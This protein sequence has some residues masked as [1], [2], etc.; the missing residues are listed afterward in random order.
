[1]SMYDCKKKYHLDKDGHCDGPLPET[2]AEGACSSYC[3]VRI[4]IK[5]GQEVPYESS[6]CSAVECTVAE[7]TG[8]STT[9]TWEINM[10]A[11]IEGGKGAV[12]GAFNIGASYSFSKTV[13]Y[14]VE[15]GEKQDL[16]EGESGYWTWVPFLVEYEVGCLL[17][18]LY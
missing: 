3:E 12:T 7:G 10:S 6:G 8:T 11:G 14:T 4:T 13:S 9:T 1:M 17:S 16:K 18:F 5:Y 2:D 15:H